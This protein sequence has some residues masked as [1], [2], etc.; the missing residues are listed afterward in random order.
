MAA[1]QY[2][3]QAVSETFS[4]DGNPL[5]HIVSLKPDGTYHDYVFPQDSLEW[6]AAEYS[7]DPSDVETLLD[8]ILHEPHKAPLNRDDPALMEGRISRAVIPS[9]GTR[10]GDYEAT[11]LFN[12]ETKKDAR[13]AHLVRIQHAK[14][15]R[16][17]VVSPAGKPDP[18]DKIRS[19]YRNEPK[20]I[21]DKR[22]AV[23]EG[24]S[25]LRKNL[26]AFQLKNRK[27]A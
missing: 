4:R 12:A 9:A 24:R 7:I 3:V 16:V 19:K 8:V 25:V 23:N 13:E 21:E 20:L 2:E 10:V 6:R 22:R 1:E 11:T 14:A 5:W 27:E 18:L 26:E 15:N 17:K